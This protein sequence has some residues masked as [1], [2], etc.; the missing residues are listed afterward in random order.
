[1][2]GGHGKF[3]RDDMDA[4]KPDVTLLQS[5]MFGAVPIRNRRLQP[6]FVREFD[7]RRAKIDHSDG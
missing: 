5:E 1:M 2:F 4:K 7:Y 6:I 3:L